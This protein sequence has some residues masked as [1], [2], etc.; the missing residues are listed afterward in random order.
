MF[1]TGCI[2]TDKTKIHS[3]PNS[4][5]VYPTTTTVTEYENCAN[6]LGI[7]SEDN[8]SIWH[9]G[10]KSGWDYICDLITL[11]SCNDDAQMVFG[12]GLL[13]SNS[14]PIPFYST[15]TE[16]RNRLKTSGFVRSNGYS[17]AADYSKIFW[18]YNFY[19]NNLE[20]LLG[21]MFKSTTTSTN[22]TTQK[23]SSIRYVK[24]KLNDLSVSST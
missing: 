23:N 19:G 1:A 22:A 4:S 17:T 7:N 5:F 13:P 9:I 3:R 21:F 15:E 18:I 14:T 2:G 11:I 10:Y 6:N 12:P 16:L 20:P 24:M 8:H